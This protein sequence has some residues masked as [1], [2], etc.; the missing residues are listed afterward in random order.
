MYQKFIDDSEKYGKPGEEIALELLQYRANMHS[1]VEDVFS[2]G[3]TDFTHDLEVKF[4]SGA[5]QKF[6][7]KCDTLLQRTGNFFVEYFDNHRARQEGWFPEYIRN[8]IEGIIT[9]NMPTN[10]VYYYRI[11]DMNQ[12]IQTHNV[13]TGSCRKDGNNHYS[14]GYKINID[15]FAKDSRCQRWKYIFVNGKYEFTPV[16][17]MMDEDDIF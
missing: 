6:D 5:V 15:D 11:K 13:S 3:D 2:C 17:F 12:Y 16:D 10:S 8:S 9:V 1:N 7:A 14:N 4:T